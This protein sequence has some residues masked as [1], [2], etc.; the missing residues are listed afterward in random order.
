MNKTHAKRS[1]SRSFPT[2]RTVQQ[3]QQTLP[4]VGD[5]SGS[6]N[7]TEGEEGMRKVTKWMRKMA[8]VQAVCHESDED[9]TEPSPT[10]WPS[11]VICVTAIKL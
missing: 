10:V 1:G 11:F 8:Q 5:D 6:S 7:L 3:N 4:A 2:S 9:L